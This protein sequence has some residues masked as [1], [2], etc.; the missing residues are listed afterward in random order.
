MSAFTRS[1][2]R[3]SKRIRFKI[4]LKRINPFQKKLQHCCEKGIYKVPEYGGECS[5]CFKKSN[6]EMYH[7]KISEKNSNVN[8]P[9][10][11]NDELE[12]ETRKLALPIDHRLYK[13]LIWCCKT[14]AIENGEELINI[15]NHILRHTIYRGW[16]SKQ[17]EELTSIYRFHHCNNTWE[18]WSAGEEKWRIQ[19]AI[20][21]GVI[22]R[23]N[24]HPD[25]HGGVGFCYYNIPKPTKFIREHGL[26]FPTKI[27]STPPC[28]QSPTFVEE[29]VSTNAFRFW[30]KSIPN[31][32]YS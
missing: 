12:E 29:V 13:N 17:A 26:S 18:G 30:R 6:P 10:Y 24:L 2:K 21:G 22:D 28:F 9:C 15:L 19:H 16:S 7:I 3:Y 4:D 32:N 31:P 23:W 5:Q 20:C 1:G 8:N 27:P 14:G 11:S 25:K